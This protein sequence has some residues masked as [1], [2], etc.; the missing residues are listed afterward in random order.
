VKRFFYLLSGMMGVVTLLLMLLAS[1]VVA[2]EELTATTKYTTALFSGPGN[3]SCYNSLVGLPAGETL[4]LI[5]RA[6]GVCAP[7]PGH[8]YF[9]V[10]RANG[11]EGWAYDSTLNLPPGANDLPVLPPPPT[12]TPVPALTATTKY[13]TALFSG[14]GN[15]TCYS[16][17]APLAG[18]ETL[19]LLGR[20]PG[21]CAPY[22][23]Q[24]YYYARR[25]NGT[26]GWAYGPVLN[27]PPGAQNL[28]LMTPPPTNTPT[29]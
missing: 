18:G 24:Y 26:E 13:T 29:P 14:P 23:G 3:I 10:R 28:P 27:L 19:T 9:Y 16:N 7:Y 21:V 17:I 12:N 22:P 1:S 2:Q 8:Q 25:A 15:I 20:A 11:T 4:T 6:P 5:G